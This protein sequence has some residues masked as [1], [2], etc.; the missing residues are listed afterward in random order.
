MTTDEATKSLNLW[1]LRP[2]APVTDFYLYS[3]LGQIETPSADVEPE[4]RLIAAV[5]YRR[6]SRTTRSARRCER[7][8]C[9]T[10]APTVCRSPI[11][12]KE[13]SMRTAGGDG[14]GRRRAAAT[15]GDRRPILAESGESG[16]KRAD[17]R[18]RKGERHGIRR[19]P[20]QSP[21]SRRSGQRGRTLRAA[22]RERRRA[23]PRRAHPR[24]RGA[25]SLRG[26]DRRR[27]VEAPRRRRPQRSRQ[28]RSLASGGQRTGDP[29]AS[30]QPLGLLAHRRHA[31]RRRA[32][33]ASDLPGHAHDDPAR[34]GHERRRPLDR[35]RLRQRR[36]HPPPKRQL[37]A[38]TTA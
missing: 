32:R 23:A 13:R 37:E 38:P 11:A 6:R 5:A 36:R 7:Q 1:N 9:C 24:R 17:G 4:S 29:P 15:G 33:R 8:R 28:H 2:A 34:P 10:R 25:P 3:L 19:K 22:H 16:R 27:R 12:V 31:D 35:H 20:R 26:A 18:C 21:A 30:Q 14:G